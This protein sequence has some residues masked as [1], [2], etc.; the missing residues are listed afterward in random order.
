MR[1]PWLNGLRVLVVEDEAVISLVIS[2]ELF[3]Y[4]YEVA[5]PFGRSAEALAWLRQNNADL[6][7]L[8]YQLK[9]G[10][11]LPV[12]RELAQRGIPFM[13]FSASYP[14]LKDHPELRDVPWIGKP[15][16]IDTLLDSLDDLTTS[17]AAVTHFSARALTL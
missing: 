5:G 15:A 16:S 12:A 4:G 7:I 10:S 17:P 3:S 2:E 9:D 13:V 8:D 6:A 1:D 14:G 11:C